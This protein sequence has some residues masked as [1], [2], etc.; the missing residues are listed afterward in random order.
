MK[1]N[2]GI[3][4]L[5]VASSWMV[6][7]ISWCVLDGHCYVLMAS[8]W[9]LIFDTLCHLYVVHPHCMQ[10]AENPP[11]LQPVPGAHILAHRILKMEGNIWYEARL[12]NLSTSILSL[13]TIFPSW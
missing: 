6:A 1:E 5:A 2:F 8:G 10:R 9:L 4:P 12:P 3:R 13:S 11:L 7:V